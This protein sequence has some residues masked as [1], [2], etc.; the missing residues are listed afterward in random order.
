MKVSPSDIRYAIVG[1]KRSD[2]KLVPGIITSGHPTR[3][4][5][6]AKKEDNDHVVGYVSVHRRGY[7]T[8]R[9]EQYQARPLKPW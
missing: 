6:E 9:A 7:H 5:A 4:D 8:V 2:G 3:K 1:L